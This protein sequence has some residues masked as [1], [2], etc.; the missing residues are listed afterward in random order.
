[1]SLLSRLCN[2]GLDALLP[3]T[4]HG[5]GE[6]LIEQEQSLCI[7]CISHLPRSF[8]WHSPSDNPMVTRFAG[9]FRFLYAISFLIYSHD[10]TIASLIHDFK[11]RSFPQLAR[12]LGQVMG[13]ELSRS[14]FLSEIDYIVPVAQHWS[15]R[16]SRGYNQSE[17]IANGITDTS[18]I[19]TLNALHAVRRHRTQTR[20]SLQ[21]RLAN[22][23]GAYCVPDPDQIADRHILLV[24]DVC[25]TG[26]TIRAAALT[27]NRDAP[28]TRLSILTLTATT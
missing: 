17:M 21:Q 10:S 24:D 5:C 12:R 15:R 20:L 2:Y 25:T 7:N 26:A 13:D 18:G 11:Y 23:R 22:P 1:M 14:G 6:I 27:I 19:P 4:C 28:K 8:F 9:Q 16:M 3:R